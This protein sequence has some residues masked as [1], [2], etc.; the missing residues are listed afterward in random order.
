L[1]GDSATP[2]DTS[3]SCAAGDGCT[4]LG[5]YNGMRVADLCTQ[6]CYT[7]TD[8]KQATYSG[9][10]PPKCDIPLMGTTKYKACTISCNPVGAALG[11]N[12]CPA[13]LGCDYGNDGMTGSV[14]E[15]TDCAPF[16]MV[17]TANPC[18]Q[19]HGDEDCKPGNICA[20]VNSGSAKCYKVCRIGQAGTD[21]P[22]GGQTCQAFGGYPNGYNPKFGICVP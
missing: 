15:L 20:T 12:G 21:C 4:T 10:L 14:F 7:D 11:T 13:G 3:D 9:G 8:C 18:N 17:D 16:G 22:N 1:C 6:F 2:P 5:D 19:M